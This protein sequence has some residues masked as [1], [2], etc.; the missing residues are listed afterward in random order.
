[1]S[2]ARIVCKACKSA[3]AVDLANAPKQSFCPECGL[4]YPVPFGSAADG[5]YYA[6]GSQKL[7]PVSF[8]QLHQMAARGELKPTDLVLQAGAI[9]W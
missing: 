6:L 8:D 7:G 1:M 2:I 9:Q 5:W 3:F 4:T